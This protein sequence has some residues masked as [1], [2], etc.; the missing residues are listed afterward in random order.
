MV[1]MVGNV[2]LKGFDYCSVLQLIAKSPLLF[3]WSDEQ[4]RLSRSEWR[5]K[6]NVSKHS[7]IYPGARVFML[8]FQFLLLSGSFL[9]SVKKV[10]LSYR[11]L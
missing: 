9:I 5:M 1:S 7:E 11:L 8:W 4:R 3:N 2:S 10:C 6:T